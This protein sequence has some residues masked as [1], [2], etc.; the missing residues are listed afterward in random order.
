[1]TLYF[2]HISTN[3]LTLH[4]F[5]SRRGSYL[6]ACLHYLALFGPNAHVIGNTEHAGLREDEALLLQVKISHL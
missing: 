3:Q 2:Q 5:R 6:S 4:L 1:M